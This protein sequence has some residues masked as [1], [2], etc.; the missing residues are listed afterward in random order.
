MRK[1]ELVVTPDDGS[2]VVGQIEQV[3]RGALA[4]GE[5]VTVARHMP[6]LTPSEAAAAL[7]I[8]R[9]SVQRRIVSGDIHAQR[10]GSR[11][12]IT[13][14]EVDRFR[15]ELVTAADG[16][17][18]GAGRQPS[19]TY[20]AVYRDVLFKFLDGDGD[21]FFDEAAVTATAAD[22]EVLAQLI[23]CGAVIA[24]GDRLSLAAAHKA[25]LVFAAAELARPHRQRWSAPE[26]CTAAIESGELIPGSAEVVLRHFDLRVN[27]IGSP[28]ITVWHG[29][30][31]AAYSETERE[32][33]TPWVD[34][35]LA[36]HV[37]LAVA[38]ADLF[39]VSDWRADE[40]ADYTL[41]RVIPPEG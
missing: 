6:E 41:R 21:R 35:G 31:P 37:P 19:H 22:R 4:A 38:Y 20:A 40:F 17:R 15:G 26:L 32:G 24:W 14:A 16:S 36:G 28:P 18:V 30:G 33:W 27:P 7:G 2:A 1:Y 29:A 23:R 3:V 8:S 5:T 39:C 10:I 11:Y 9:A 13:A 12:R 25:L 34:D